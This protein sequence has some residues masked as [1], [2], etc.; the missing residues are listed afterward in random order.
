LLRKRE[1]KEGKKKEEGSAQPAF[2]LTRKEI[3]SSSFW[4]KEKEKIDPSKTIKN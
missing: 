1:K 2:S 3:G 4:P